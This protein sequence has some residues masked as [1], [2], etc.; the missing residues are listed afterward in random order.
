MKSGVRRRWR[1]KK[2]GR[3]KEIRRNK[4]EDEE[5]G[6]KKEEE[7]IRMSKKKKERGRI[8]KK[9]GR[10][11]SG[12]RRRRKAEEEGRKKKEIRKS[13]KKEEEEEGRK[14]KKEGS[15]R[16]EYEEGRRKNKKEGSR[17]KSEGVRRRKNKK[18]GRRRRRRR[19]KEEA[20]LPCPL[21]EATHSNT[22]TVPLISTLTFDG[23]KWFIS[24]TCSF[25]PRKELRY[26]LNRTL[27]GPRSWRGKLGEGKNLVLLQGFEPRITVRISHRTQT[28]ST[29]NRQ[30]LYGETLAVRN[31]Q[32]TYTVLVQWRALTGK[33]CST[34]SNH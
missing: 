29:R 24:R 25:I 11:K 14:D 12:V 33:P 34:Y 26:P 27:C 17:R 20:S 4:K 9:E 13:K 21:H 15:R 2:E 28:A 31:I 22:A 7:G 19:K 10:R 8:S 1:N 3:K 23:G 16:K 30:V 32:Y 6:R 18:E 5:E